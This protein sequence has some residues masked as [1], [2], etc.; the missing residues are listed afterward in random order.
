MNGE[1]KR[2]NDEIRRRREAASA[3]A[4]PAHMTAENT[5]A[6]SERPGAEHRA[7]AGT[8]S[9]GRPTGESKAG[10][11][12]ETSM[13]TETKS[14]A[15]REHTADYVFR[16]MSVPKAIAKNTVPAVLAMLMVLSTIWP[17]HFSSARRTSR[18]K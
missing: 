16:S 2:K 4:E 5:A 11:K 15:D 1:K 8:A 7:A 10:M 17:I 14:A 18:W 6:E 9:A 13:E 12:T 3:A